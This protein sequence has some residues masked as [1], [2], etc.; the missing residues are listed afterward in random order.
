[1][2][3]RAEGTDANGPS[4]SFVPLV[5]VFPLTLTDILGAVRRHWLIV[6]GVVLITVLVV[7][8]YVAVESRTSEPTRYRTEVTLAIPSLHP[9]APETEESVPSA[10]IRNQTSVPGATAVRQAAI[11]SA[12][13]PPDVE[14]VSFETSLNE[15]ETTMTLGVTTRNRTLSELVADEYANAVVER[16]REIVVE[17]NQARNERI[18]ASIERLRGRALEVEAELGAL[19][20]Q[21]TTPQSDQTQGDPQPILDQPTNVALLNYEREALFREIAGLQRQAGELAVVA[22][23][24]NAYA[25]R[26]A[27]RTH[28]IGASSRSPLIPL[29]LLLAG[30]A[31]AVGAAVLADRLDH[32][33]R[34]SR[35]AQ[36][37]FGARVLSTIPSKHRRRDIGV[38]RG[39]RSDLN[40][41]YRTL[42]ATSI[43][44][45]QLPKAIMVAAPR[46]HAHDELAANYAAALA[47][48]GLTVALVATSSRQ[49]WYADHFE[50]PGNAPTVSDL[51]SQAHRGELLGDLTTH[52]PFAPSRPELVL[53]PPGEDTGL[54]L[55]LDGLPPL[56][57]ALSGA[58]V[59]VTVIAGPPLLDDPDATLIAWSTGSV[60]WACQLGDCVT[61][62]AA[63]GA[64]RLELTNVDAFGVTT[65]GAET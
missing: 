46:G 20:F 7:G 59:D 31:A 12:G 56:L 49:Q 13:L 38:L 65:L 21:P 6:A 35:I 2:V 17:Y 45:D 43:A 61:D 51:L 10:V 27:I 22:T 25:E 19:G 14:D 30:L 1:M 37:A 11:E 50:G 62:D 18:L 4:S 26:V 33:I 36:R 28:R 58:G 48:L 41:A 9:D 39:E 47:G 3:V 54:D 42:A 29:A 5:E 15:T 40:D 34:T 55:P 53:V 52:L 64:T 16:R 60:L 57:D 8:A 24:P 32:T 23:S 44:T 63:L